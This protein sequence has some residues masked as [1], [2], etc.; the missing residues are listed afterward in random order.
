MLKGDQ[1]CSGR[2]VIPLWTYEMDL[3][4]G[5]SVS[6]DVDQELLLWETEPRLLGQR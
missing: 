3:K 4:H 1:P 5:L 6:E 2:G